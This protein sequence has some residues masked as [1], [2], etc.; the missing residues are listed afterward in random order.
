MRQWFF[1]FAC[2]ITLAAVAIAQVEDVPT[3]TRV[4]FTPDPRQLQWGSG[5]D[6]GNAVILETPELNPQSDSRSAVREAE[7]VLRT[8]FLDFGLGLVPVSSV[9]IQNQQLVNPRQWTVL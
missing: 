5:V 7:R 8:P 3:P 4:P 2:C 6:L 9:A 1:P